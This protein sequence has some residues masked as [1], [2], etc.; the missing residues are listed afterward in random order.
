MDSKRNWVELKLPKSTLL[1]YLRMLK[2]I[3]KKPKLSEELQ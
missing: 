3:N 1:Y 2:S